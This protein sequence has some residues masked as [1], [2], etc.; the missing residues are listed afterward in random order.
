MLT[1]ATGWTVGH[2]LLGIN[3]F[4]LLHKVRHFHH[5]WLAQL[6]RTFRTTN[7]TE[8]LIHHHSHQHTILHICRILLPLVL[9]DT[10]NL[11]VDLALIVRILMMVFLWLNRPV[12]I[13]K[14]EPR[15]VQSEYLPKTSL[16][17]MRSSWSRWNRATDVMPVWTDGTK[18]HKGQVV[19]CLCCYCSTLIGPFLKEGI[20]NPWQ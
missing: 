4:S 5:V 8:S 17:L 10:D 6:C 15:T 2:L 11:Q 9:M 16:R 3:L 20:Q 19:W 13:C 1:L 7:L 14:S 18:M 12:H